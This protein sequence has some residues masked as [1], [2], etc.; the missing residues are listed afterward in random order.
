MADSTA[1]AKAGSVASRF[2]SFPVKISVKPAP[3]SD[4]NSLSINS[5]ARNVSRSAEP[6]SLVDSD[7]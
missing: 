7:V 5:I 2:G 6:R 3:L 1:A 4:G